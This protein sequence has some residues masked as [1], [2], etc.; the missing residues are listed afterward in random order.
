MEG[1]DNQFCWNK[2]RD[3]REVSFLASNLLLRRAAASAELAAELELT[4]YAAGLP[5]NLYFSAGLAAG[6]LRTV[7]PM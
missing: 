1:H 6:R 7:K 3:R 4:K 5:Q 2:G